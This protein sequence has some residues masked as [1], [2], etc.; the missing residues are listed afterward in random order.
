MGSMT[1]RTGRVLDDY[2]PEVFK[3]AIAR[4]LEEGTHDPSRIRV[5][6]EEVRCATGEKPTQIPTFGTHVPERDVVPHDL[7]GYDV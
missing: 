3:K 1:A 7:G 4:V 2:G 6:C 5:V